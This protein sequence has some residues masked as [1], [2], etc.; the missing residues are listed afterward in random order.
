MHNS[1]LASFKQPTVQTMA[2]PKSSYRVKRRGEQTTDTTQFGATHFILWGQSA[3]LFFFREK[4]GE[5][6]ISKALVTPKAPLPMS[7]Y[8]FN[9]TVS[10]SRN[11][12]EGKIS[13][14]KKQMER[15]HA[16][17]Q[18]IRVLL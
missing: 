12:S 6:K 13:R 5:G 3:S 17:A 7:W 11:K 9:T 18:M 8:C 10:F 16:L 1:I 4:I 14:K 15:T 2:V